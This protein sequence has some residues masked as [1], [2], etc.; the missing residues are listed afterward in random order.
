MDRLHHSR[1][2]IALICLREFAAT[3]RRL[4][5]APGS[6]NFL[7]VR[8][9]RARRLG[10]DDK[11]DIRLV[12][13]HAESDRGNHNQPILLREPTFD[14]AAVLVVGGDPDLGQAVQVVI[15]AFHGILIDQP[16]GR[17]LGFLRAEEQDD[18]GAGETE[19]AGYTL[20]NADARY[21]LDLP[22]S[23]LQLN[24]ALEEQRD[25]RAELER[26]QQSSK[27]RKA[28]AEADEEMV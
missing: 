17:H 21:N 23:S 7:V 11:A 15:D 4:A 18:L 12:H 1:R 3:T 14:D 10:M 24:L 8:L 28:A 6:S 5:V 2:Y 27:A 22:D 19:T 26:V 16:P 13:A 9:N 20:L 25:F